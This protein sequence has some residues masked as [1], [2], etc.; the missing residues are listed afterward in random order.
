[1]AQTAKFTI[2]PEYPKTGSR[3]YP[4]LEYQ[5]PP[6]RN[7]NKYFPTTHDEA[8]LRW[9]VR[10]KQD[11]GYL[12]LRID[13]LVGLARCRHAFAYLVSRDYDYISVLNIAVNTQV[14]GVEWFN[15]LN[16]R[17]YFLPEADA[18]SDALKR[19]SNKLKIKNAVNPWTLPY[20]EAGGITGYR[21]LPYPGFDLV[22]E[23]EALSTAPPSHGWTADDY[24]RVIDKNLRKY[25][26]GGTMTLDEWLWDNKFSTSGGSYLARMDITYDGKKHDFKA[27][28][29]SLLDTLTVAE[30]KVLMK[31]QHH[32][33]NRVFP[34]N[35]LT[36]VR[37]ALSSD[38]LNYL[39]QAY[40]CYRSGDIMH[41]WEEVVSG[42]NA[43]ETL[44]RMTRMWHAVQRKWNMP[45]DFASFDHQI[46]TMLIVMI[47]LVYCDNAR[48]QW[49]A[50][51]D[52]RWCIDNS[53]GN[54][55]NSDIVLRENTAGQ[56]N[57]GMRWKQK[58][59]LSS[60][61]YI[62]AIV[63]SGAN[64]VWKNLVTKVKAQIKGDDTAFTADTA[65]ELQA[66][67]NEYATHNIVGGVGKFGILY[68]ASEFLRTWYG[69]DRV[70]GYPARTTPGLVQRK[71]WSNEPWSPENTMRNLWDLVVIIARRLQGIYHDGNVFQL[72]WT[73]SRRWS[74]L[75]RLP[76]VA[77]SIPKELGGF[78]ISPW[79]GVSYI[80]PKLPSFPSAKLQVTPRTTY[81]ATRLRDR[82]AYF[83]IILKQQSVEDLV[84]EELVQKVSSDSY[85]KLRRFLRDTWNSWLK[86]SRFR[87]YKQ[88]PKFTT[89]PNSPIYDD[90]VEHLK[91]FS[92]SYGSATH[93]YALFKSISPVLRYG[94]VKIKEFIRSRLAI[95]PK[96]NYA[97]D[98][99]RGHIA[100]LLD[101]YGGNMSLKSVCLQ[102]LLNGLASRYVAYKVRTYP[103][104][105][106]ALTAFA[107][108]ADALLTPIYN[109]YWYGA[110]CKW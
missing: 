72:W 80:E 59:K 88:E 98:N 83:S 86:K 24:Q 14:F 99:D 105:R 39:M 45:W 87:V 36:K 21:T 5:G 33:E 61:I 11:L 102:P 26:H 55:S 62:T 96:L 90:P 50:D 110:I 38:D 48:V 97:I 13:D 89:T 64:V 53:V 23:A 34:K 22:A 37:L 85:P 43:L 70:Y 79:D 65:E 16:S 67:L 78:G 40:V 6:L 20:V 109:T 71:P 41:E 7:S 60:G 51:D 19:L 49:P 77:L 9:P 56:G 28:K 35:E 42:E 69:E 29:N 31:A 10:N 12:R 93:E 44:Q 68:S 46:E 8:L 84:N 58:G 1:M 103:K 100:E 57:P 107:A 2:S 30:I 94:K 18:C 52:L 95:F 66:I 3:I 27:Q 108:H 74:A 82:A 32:Q 106:W 15:N 63:G 54:F 25:I 47:Y 17:G 92:C 81:A 76:Q 75:H 4:F 101:W 91:T 73:V 104:R